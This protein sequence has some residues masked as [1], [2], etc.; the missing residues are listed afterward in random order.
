[1][2]PALR[3]LR[4]L[5]AYEPKPVSTPQSE[6]GSFLFSGLRVPWLTT[7]GRVQLPKDE[8]FEKLKK[9]IECWLQHHE[10]LPQSDDLHSCI[11]GSCTDRSYLPCTLAD[12][13][14]H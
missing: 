11:G 10:P 8:F 14:A 7:A 1:M 9:R 12:V 2:T 4:I 13:C 6:T 5:L 3:F